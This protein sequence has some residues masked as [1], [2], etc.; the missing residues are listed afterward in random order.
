MSDETRI[1]VT[2]GDEQGQRLDRALARAVPEE[3]AL[4]RSRLQVLIQE[5]AVSLAD[6]GA[7]LNDPSM[8]IGAEVALV[9]DVPPAIPTTTEAEDIPL[10]I[11]FEDE[12][13]IVVNKPVGLVVH[14]APG[15]RTGT[16][17]NGLLH[18]C[19][20]SLSG[21]GGALRP[22]IVHR[23]DKDT[24]G[25]LVVAKSDAA[26]Q[27]LAVQF[28]DHSIDRRYLAVLYGAPERSDPKLNGL[29][30]VSW[31]SGG[32]L[33]IEGN[34]GRHP[35]DR[36]RMT[37]LSRGG[38]HAVTR[39]KVLERFG[40]PKV[41]ASL[42]ECQLETGRTH[43]IRVHMT[44]AGHPLAGDRVYGRHGGAGVLT[45]FPRQ[46]LHAARLGFEHPVTGERKVFEAPLPE[47]MTGLVEGLREGR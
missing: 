31:E 45:A 28:A 23:I 2:T 33:R 7:V 24:S 9:I 20:D 17:V 25:L 35:G 44:F 37:V 36:K 27:G 46:A 40:S 22:G 26:H 13:L 29:H 18:H 11:I 34:V 38:K 19:R 39:A 32:V 16:L 42:V 14:P 15:A 1:T 5:G 30:G 41:L 10:D 4:S 47:D 3:L 21:I 8:K 43:Q 6:T 12:H